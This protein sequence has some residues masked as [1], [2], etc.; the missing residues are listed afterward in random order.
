MV[1]FFA[2]FVLSAFT[3]TDTREIAL[4]PRTT[5]VLS[6][7]SRDHFHNFPALILPIPCDK[8]FA[9]KMMIETNPYRAYTD[10]SILN[11][12]PIG[13]VIALY[14]GA[15]ESSA[16]ARNFLACKD[17]PS[18]T[19]AINKIIGIL[20][21][22]MRS[23]D[24]EKGGEISRNLR[25]LYVYIQG[26]VTEAHFRQDAAPLLEVE[27]LFSTMLEGWKGAKAND[28]AVPA[29]HA[30]SLVIPARQSSIYQEDDTSTSDMPYSGYLPEMSEAAAG[31]AYSF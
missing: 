5:P 13:L 8:D 25:Q 3:C 14:E 6:W 30:T 26:R 9:E 27:K 18:R 11:S 22:L 1:S 21:E 20:T 19:K 28:N 2:S 23:L 31:S 15:I 24:D 4:D 16:A 17:I 10:D 29:I 7:E 12:D